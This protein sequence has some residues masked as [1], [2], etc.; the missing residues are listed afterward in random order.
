MRW[1]ISIDNGVDAVIIKW[2]A[3]LEREQNTFS[4]HRWDVAMHKSRSLTQP[5][6]DEDASR[7]A[8]NRNISPCQ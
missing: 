8:A 5:S 1:R 2:V 7:G 3:P 6:V 4:G